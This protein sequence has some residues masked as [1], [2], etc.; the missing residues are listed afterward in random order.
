MFQS[1]TGADVPGLES[2]DPADYF[3]YKNLDFTAPAKGGK[4]KTFFLFQPSR[5]KGF[6]GVSMT[7][8]SVP[9]SF[10]GYQKSSKEF[11]KC[12]FYCS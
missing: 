8:Q 7:C 3:E 6:L 12:P 4:I 1:T 2:I 9:K 5:N 11:P 10:E